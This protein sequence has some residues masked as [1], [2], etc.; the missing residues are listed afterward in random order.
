MCDKLKTT[1]LLLIIVILYGIFPIPDANAQENPEVKA[2]QFFDS[3]NFTEAEKIFQELLLNDAGSPILNYYYGASRTENGHYGEKELEYLRSAGKNITP[4]RLHYYLAIQYHARGEWDQALKL[5][6]QFRL[7]VPE[8]EQK[9]LDLG[10]KI[11][12]C[13][14]QVNPFDTASVVSIREAV[15]AAPE[16]PV[17]A[18]QKKPEIQETME[19]NPVPLSASNDPDNLIDVTEIPAQNSSGDLF[20]PREALPDLPGVQTTIPDGDPVQF[21]INSTI[22]YFYTSQFQT[23]EGKNLFEK[24]KTLE[25]QQKKNLEEAEKLRTAYKNT[26]STDEREAIATKIIGLENESFNLEEEIKKIYLESRIVENEYWENAG[27]VSRNNFLMEQEK[28]ISSLK[29]S[30]EDPRKPEEKIL[31]DII[32]PMPKP[33]AKAIPS[34]LTYKIQ[35]GAYSKGVPDYRQRLYNKLS[36]IRTIDSYTDEKG[37]VVYTTGNLTRYED[38][39]KMQ[40]QVKQEGIQDASVVPYFNGKRITLEQAKQMEANNDI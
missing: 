37:V 25:L 40:N 9:E 20:L 5:Y 27:P 28:L 31:I 21:Q 15:R 36:V 38:A 10:K 39:L 24:A 16:E 23:E 13:Y 26:Q 11:Q 22:T 1:S 35:I 8:M 6:N 14:N 2:I 30:N 7:S 3:G 34:E 4:D 12:L 33:S 32:E 17:H 19:E 29:E 18:E